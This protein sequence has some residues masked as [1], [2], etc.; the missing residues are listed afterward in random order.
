MR[1]ADATMMLADPIRSAEL[2]A[3]AGE[4]VAW[5]GKGEGELR[6]CNVYWA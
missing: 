3:G 4:V 5:A 6:G 2:A 1:I